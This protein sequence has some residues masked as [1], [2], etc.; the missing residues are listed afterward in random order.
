MGVQ[1]GPGRRSPERDLRDPR[2]GVGHARAAETDLCR[3]A[4]ELLAEGHRD[5][6]HEV[7]AARLDDRLEALGLG[8]ERT[9]EGGERR[10][11]LPGRLGEDGE[12]DGRGEDVVR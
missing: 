1:P 11:E 12:M 6:V 9:L 7:G 10:E 5:G 4:G 3:V 2:Q 8:R